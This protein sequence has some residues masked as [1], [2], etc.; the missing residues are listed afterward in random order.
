MVRVARLHP[1]ARPAVQC[2]ETG[3]AVCLERTHAQFF[4][5]GQSLPLEVCGK[6]ATGGS[7]RTASSPWRYRA[8]ASLARSCCMPAS[9]SASSARTWASSKR[10][11]ASMLNPK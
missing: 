6:R 10:P 11:P 8:Y 1:T 3:V 5:Q 4:G 9:D 7:R 2:A